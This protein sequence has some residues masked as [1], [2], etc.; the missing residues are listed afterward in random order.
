MTITAWRI[1]KAARADKAFD[2]EGARLYGGRWNSVGTPVVYLAENAALAVL[3]LLVHIENT[4]AIDLYVLIPV[5]FE[6]RLV[7]T[8]PKNSI[9]GDWSANPP[10]STTQSIGDRWLA[11]GRDLLLS[12]PSA[13]VPTE[14]NFLL[15]PKHPD[16]S[17]VHIGAPQEFKFD[18]RLFMTPRSGRTS[19]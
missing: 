4:A 10:S 6:S 19:A 12:V 18:A 17:R 7:R 14:R 3:E 16:F 13:L 2:G 8:L 11:Q 9:P 15:N 1:T 5:A